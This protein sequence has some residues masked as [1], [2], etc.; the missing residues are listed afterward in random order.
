[1]KA[2]VYKEQRGGNLVAHHL[3]GY[4]WDVENRFNLDNGITLCE[5]CHIEFHRI[6]GFGNNTKKQF[7][8]FRDNVNPKE[9]KE[10]LALF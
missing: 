8:Y 6:Y 10:Q 4:N 5:D 3:N 9:Y 1:M 7:E 2:V